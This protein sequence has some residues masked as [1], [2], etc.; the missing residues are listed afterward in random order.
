MLKDNI[1]KARL[2]AGLTQLEVA[3]KLGVACDEIAFVGDTFYTDILGAYRAN[4]LPIW[5]FTDTHR[6]SDHDI[7]RIFSLKEL[8]EIF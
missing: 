5:F 7:K 3:E 2:D 6:V 1:K 8:L 4:M